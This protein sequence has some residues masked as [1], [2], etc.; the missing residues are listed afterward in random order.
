MI[1]SS[2]SSAI[3]P[4]HGDL[5]SESAP[6]EQSLRNTR[7]KLWELQECWHCMV[8]G[9]C[10]TLADVRQLA[11]KAGTRIGAV[12]DYGVHRL[13]D[14]KHQTRIRQL[15]PARDTD[16]PQSLWTTGRQS[17]G[18]A[19]EQTTRQLCNNTRLERLLSRALSSRQ[20][21]G[22]DE[23]PPLPGSGGIVSG[24]LSASR[25]RP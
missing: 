4:R 14:R 8:I 2:T 20:D 25:W 9:T 3:V 17:G 22:E 6:S 7:F 1:A 16:T 15:R 21:S 5:L 12:S 24:P 23:V 11:A 10:L 18:I 19:R 13:L